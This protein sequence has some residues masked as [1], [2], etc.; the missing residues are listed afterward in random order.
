MDPRG[1]PGISYLKK[2]QLLYELRLRGLPTEGSVPELATRLRAGIESS[3]SI[4]PEVVGEVGPCLSNVAT[5]LEDIRRNLSF[6]EGTQPTY[7]QTCRLQ[8]HLAH[9]GS[10]LTDLTHLKLKED[11]GQKVEQLLALV[12]EL[13]VKVSTLCLENEGDEVGQEVARGSQAR[14]QGLGAIAFNPLPSEQFAKLPNPI[15]HLL[16]NVSELSVED[17]EEARRTLWLLVEFEFHAEALGVQHRV[18]LALIYPLAKGALSVLIGDNLRQQGSISQLREAILTKGLSARMRNELECRYYWRVQDPTETLC[19]YVQRVR[20][21]VSALSMRVNEAETI[22]Y[23]LEGI[24]PEDRCRLVFAKPPVTFL[25]LQALVGSVQ[26]IKFADEQRQLGARAI[27]STSE[28][29][30]GKFESSANRSA[31][32]RCFRCGAHEH[33]VRNCPVT[34]GPRTNK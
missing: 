32:R 24:R 5:A 25:E 34:R 10:R 13:Q 9:W 23:L 29:G 15:M 4:T 18:I 14:E 1:C 22:S 6:L 31:H 11:E 33:L 28:N 3:L 16:S 2:D 12:R 30:K 17:L 7:K 21:A 19:Q 26:A 8:A 20:V 27:F